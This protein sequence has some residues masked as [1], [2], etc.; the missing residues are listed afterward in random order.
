MDPCPFVRIVVG[1]LALKFPNPSK[2]TFSGVHAASSPCYCKIKFKN[3][4][5]QTATIPLISTT[6]PHP[7]HPNSIL[8]SAAF[9]LPHSAILK[10]SKSKTTPVL[11]IDVYKG[12]SGSTL[13][14][15]SGK[16]LG[17]VSVP[18]DLNC[19]L[20]SK[21]AVF[22]NGWVAVGDGGGKAAQM[23]V[24]VKAEPDPRFV[25]EFGGEPECSPLVFQVQ[26]SFKQPVFT[27]KFSLRDNFR[28]RSSISES[29][30]SRTWLSSFGQE[31]KESSTKERKGWSITIHDLS[32][33]PV[34]AASMVT[35]FVPTPG[36]DRVS[37]TNPGAWLILRPGDATWKPWGR[38]EAWLE[39]GSTNTL[40]Y[41]FDLLPD[42]TASSVG[43]TLAASSLKKG[44]RFQL[45]N[46]SNM[47]S[48]T[49]ASPSIS[50]KGSGDYSG[51]HE[52]R[53]GFV[54]SA[55]AGRKGGGPEVEVGVKHVS[56]TEDAAAF[57]ALAAAVDLSVDACKLFT[58][59]LR[60]ELQAG[61]QQGGYGVV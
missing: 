61:Q 55:T 51:W 4:T 58:R 45:D 15:N 9:T 54:M 31:Q 23:Y 48:A 18:L 22:K 14:L 28:S 13:G 57:V 19:G 17:R 38:L 1:N 30:M 37:R 56:C 50:P 10:L 32:G 34:A 26:G 11:K 39:R 35:P 52:L 33:S 60:K 8:Q 36:S 59:K 20:E 53:R 29:S 42:A 12:K 49:G 25:F 5:S 47:L 7:D 2:P 21:G 27:C 40:G 43:T 16:L 41:R 6:S 44:E 46:S 24:S 3:F